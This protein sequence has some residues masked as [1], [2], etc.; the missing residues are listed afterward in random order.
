MRRN[1]NTAQS[2]PVFS[3]P[4]MIF[5]LKSYKTNKANSNIRQTEQAVIDKLIVSASAA[6]RVKL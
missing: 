5:I 4:R 6:I 1:T 3:N 2:F